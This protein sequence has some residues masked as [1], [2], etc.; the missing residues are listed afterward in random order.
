[1]CYPSRVVFY[2]KRM[3]MKTKRASQKRVP[4]AH[5]RWNTLG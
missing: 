5:G 2:A 1:M 4:R 3:Q